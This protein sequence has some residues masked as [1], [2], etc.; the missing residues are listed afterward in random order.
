MSIGPVWTT[1]EPEVDRRSGSG[2]PRP[3]QELGAKLERDWLAVSEELSA[4]PEL[5]AEALE[6]A[7]LHR[8]VSPAD[9]LRASVPPIGF[10]RQADVMAR[11]G[12]PPITL[13]AGRRLHLS[14][15]YWVDGT[16]SIHQHAFSGAFQ[17]LAGGSLQ[18]RYTF[19][20][21]LALGVYKTGR[22]Q[23]IALERVRVGD[24][25]RIEPG[26]SGLIHSL[27]H[28]ERPSV[29][30][31]IRTWQDRR[32]EPQYNYFRPGIATDPSSRTSGRRACSRSPI[33]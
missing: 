17:V 22:L 3:F 32:D 8:R 1:G 26:E 20:T 18:T 33:C 27:F 14:A 11:F 7:A 19:T 29:T 15:L 28:L 13:Y 31:V 16:T 10:P 23:P 5:A 6:R 12:Q 21:D 30:L 9:V 2:D 24:V 4:F 25:W